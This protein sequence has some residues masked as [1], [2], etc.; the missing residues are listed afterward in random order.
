M[1]LRSKLVSR[2]FLLVVLREMVEPGKRKFRSVR[3]KKRKGFKLKVEVPHLGA[4][5]LHNNSASAI[6]ILFPTSK[7]LCLRRSLEAQ[8]QGSMRW[9]GGG[10]EQNVG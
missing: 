3:R 4:F 9:G 6:L 5:Y 1:V 10:G 2:I 8:G 7:T